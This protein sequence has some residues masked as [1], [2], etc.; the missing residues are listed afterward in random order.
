MP[1]TAPTTAC[2]R[3]MTFLRD[4]W[5]GTVPAIPDLLYLPCLARHGALHGRGNI[6]RSPPLQAGARPR[7]G[8]RIG[9]SAHP[10]ALAWINVP[11]VSCMHLRLCLAVLVLGCA[12]VST[13][14]AADAPPAEAAEARQMLERLVSFRS[15]AGQAGVL[16]LARYLGE[17]FEEAGFPASDIEL[18]RAQDEVA[19]IVRYRPAAAATKAPVVF[20]G[21]MD[22]VDAVAADWATDPWVLTEKDGFLYGRGAVDNKYGVLTLAQAFMRLRREGFV[23][24]R[25]LVL[26]LSG[27]EETSRM[28]TTRLL[29]S[30]L[31]GA[32]FAVNSDAGGGYRGGNGAATYAIQAAE[33]TYA[34][35]EFTTRNEGG[36]S[37]APRADNAIYELA[38]ALQKL[39]AHRFPVK[40]NAVSL[41]AFAALAPTVGGALGQ[42]MAR[43][44]SQPGDAG[45][46]ATLEKEAW[47]DRD[48]RTTCVATML[49]AGIAENVLAGAATATVNCRIFPGETIAGVQSELARVAAN[50]ALEIKV[51]GDPVESPVSEVPVEARRAL[52]AVLAVRA[53]GASVSTYMEAGGTDGLWFRRAGI[54]T[55]AMGPLFSSDGS[56]YNFHGN[57]ERLPL[58]EFHGG[59]DHYY[60]FIQALARPVEM[61]R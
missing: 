41:D 59:L 31:E 18:L 29:A 8:C 17:R 36:H 47:V 35:F 19:L 4:P 45:A 34:T 11:G 48:L 30:R 12:C 55:V 13:S 23:P 38:A 56:H 16:P 40:W 7:H 57:N 52:E 6:T 42:A 39:A 54:P 58:A 2:T 24:D 51:L 20:L 44:A 43:F 22:V 60:L 50:P 3:P 25:E 14:R 49:K 61:A 33:K 10:C 37:S 32:A 28:Q 53:P 15:V 5:P 26:A 21:H 27:D 46:V 1:P 9:L